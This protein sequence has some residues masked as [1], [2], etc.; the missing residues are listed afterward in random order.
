[1]KGGPCAVCHLCLRP[2][3]DREKEKK[4]H[5]VFC[6]APKQGINRCRPTGYFVAT[7]I[8]T[9][10]MIHTVDIRV[11]IRQQSKVVGV[12]RTNDIQSKNYE[13]Q[14]GTRW[15]PVQMRVFQYSSQSI[16]RLV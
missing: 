12:S 11:M 3:G 16:I 6:L 13:F 15:L 2:C 4:Q 1:M 7:E 10:G 5:P 8:Y 14:T 9:V